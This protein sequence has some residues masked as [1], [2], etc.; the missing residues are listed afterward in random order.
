MLY[1]A[2]NGAHVGVVTYNPRFDKVVFIHGPEHPTKDW[3]YAADHRAGTIV[4]VTQPLKTVNLDARDI[5]PPFT[6]G[7]LRGGSHVHVYDPNGEWVSFTYEDAVMN[8]LGL[9]Q[10]HDLNQ[11]NVGISAPVSAVTVGHDNPRNRDGSMFT[12]LGP[13]EIHR[14]LISAAPR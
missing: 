3:S 5:T 12:V 9:G 14:E 13:V 1:K 11:R 4:D 7:A 2:E 6:P 10:G 8:A